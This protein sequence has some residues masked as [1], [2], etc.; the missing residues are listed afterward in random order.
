MT[1]LNTHSDPI[2]LEMR[3]ITKEFPGVKALAEVNLRVKAGEIHAIC[4]ENGAGKS[5][6]MK[7]L[8][9]VYPYGTYTGDIVYQSEVQQFKDIRASEHAGIVIIHQELALIP[10]L[11]I[12]ENHRIRLNEALREKIR[13][14]EHRYYVLDDPEMAKQFDTFWQT[15]QADSITRMKLFKLAWDMTG[16]EFAGRHLQYEKFY[17]GA[18]FIIRN[19]S[20]RETDWNEFN[21]LVDK[22]MAHRADLI[23]DA[24]RGNVRRFVQVAAPA[25][26]PPLRRRR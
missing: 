14:H 21:T 11:S 17:A 24:I 7:V 18:S 16:S 13:Y 4:G 23:D 5:T 26:L 25:R 19:H 1:S 8:S 15:P 9:G 3:S 22:V 20:Y 6:L 10:L 12:T 2:I